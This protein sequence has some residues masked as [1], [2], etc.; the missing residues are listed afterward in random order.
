[1]KYIVKREDI[2]GEISGYPIEIIQAAVDRGVGQGYNASVVIRDLQ[3]STACG[4]AWSETSEGT[5]F[6][7]Q[8]MCRHNF[9]IFFQRYPRK[10]ADGVHYLV[11]DKGRQ[12]FVDV[13]KIF[14]GERPRFAFK[15]RSGDI[16]Y[17]VKYGDN[18]TTG[19]ALKDS[20]H[21][22]WAIENGTEINL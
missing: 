16:F 3:Y 19:F 10:L 11:I 7:S 21:Y 12:H 9:S 1:M 15:G 20:P 8:V 13:A 22:R 2:C 5:E 4:F 17:V 18:T 14:L 6:W